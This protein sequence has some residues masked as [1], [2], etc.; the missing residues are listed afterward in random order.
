MLYTGMTKLV[1]EE[2]SQVWDAAN[3]GVAPWQGVQGVG[4][5]RKIV[6][7]RY[8]LAQAMFALDRKFM[9]MPAIKIG[10]ARDER[11][12]RLLVRF[13]A[14]CPTTLTTRSGVLWQSSNVQGTGDSITAA[15]IDGFKNL[16]T[17]YYGAPAPSDGHPR[18][19]PTMN[20][21]HAEGCFEKNLMLKA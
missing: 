9:A 18:V 16:A 1:S 11:Q 6:N 13:T 7:M 15:T 8:C 21:Q 14:S 5:Q 2:H 20:A 10:L 19:P 17:E 4:S 3:S 12:G